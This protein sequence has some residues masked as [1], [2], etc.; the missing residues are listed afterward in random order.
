[1]EMKVVCNQTVVYNES[2]MF[3]MKAI[4]RKLKK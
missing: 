2:G 4:Y 1:M 3:A